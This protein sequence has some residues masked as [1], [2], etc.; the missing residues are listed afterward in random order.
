MSA[1]IR[2]MDQHKKKI[3]LEHCFKWEFRDVSSHNPHGTLVAVFRGQG[4]DKHAYGA[5]A[6]LWTAGILESHLQPKER[7]GVPYTRVIPRH[8][9][10]EIHLESRAD[11]QA[12]ARMAASR[13]HGVYEQLVQDTGDMF[14][15]VDIFKN[16]STLV[17][18]V[19]EPLSTPPS[20]GGRGG[21]SRTGG[22]VR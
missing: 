7:T 16:S 18:S 17:H 8:G 21:R 5:A 12:L 20:R 3:H 1:T 22:K 19:D 9:D 15:A 14:G 2:G 4:A 10:Y 6:H 13:Y 11:Q